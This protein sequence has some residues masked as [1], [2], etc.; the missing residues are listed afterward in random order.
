MP[1]AAAALGLACLGLTV[2]L[3]AMFGTASPAVNAVNAAPAVNAV[4]AAPAVAGSPLNAA[5]AVAGS[6]ASRA[7]VPG[8][9]DGGNAF[10]ARPIADRTT[11]APQ[12]RPGQPRLVRGHRPSGGRIAVLVGSLIVAGLLVFAASRGLIWLMRRRLGL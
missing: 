11:S 9:A 12:P 7:F 2:L 1:A 8:G 5:L 6:A 10:R 3:S 4:N